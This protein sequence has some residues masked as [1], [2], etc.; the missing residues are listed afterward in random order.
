MNTNINSDTKKVYRIISL[1]DQCS[2]LKVYLIYANIIRLSVISFYIKKVPQ[3]L[4][5]NQETISFIFNQH[6]YV[7]KKALSSTTLN[8]N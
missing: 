6:I 4:I 2:F 5:Y 7:Q 3:F 8:L 1:N